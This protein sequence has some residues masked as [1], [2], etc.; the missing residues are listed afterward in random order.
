MRGRG[1]K[2]KRESV[3]IDRIE[4][5]N[6][7]Y[8]PLQRTVGP[9]I[10]YQS[11]TLLLQSRSSTNRTSSPMS[12]STFNAPSTT[13]SPPVHAPQQRSSP[14]VATPYTLHSNNPFPY[15]H[16]VAYLAAAETPTTSP[17]LHRQ[18]SPPCN[19]ETLLSPPGRA[20]TNQIT[21]STSIQGKGYRSGMLHNPTKT[22]KTT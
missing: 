15:L 14:L 5:M 11:K 20:E 16:C 12:T 18:M 13:Y 19:D 3:S 17:F 6:A 8:P 21:K 4:C 1:R 10:R 9:L 7:I 22:V 2:R